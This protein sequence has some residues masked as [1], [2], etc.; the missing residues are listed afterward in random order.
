MVRYTIAG[1]RDGFGSQ[2]HGIMAGIAYCK[3]MNYEYVHTPMSH[4]SHSQN[5]NIKKFNNLIGIPYSQNKT[6]D[7]DI[8]KPNSFT[9]T[10]IGKNPDSYFTNDVIK[11]IRNYYY[12]NSKPDIEEIDIAIHVRRGDVSDKTC[13]EKIKSRY[14]SND[15]YVKI[16][17]FMRKKYPNLKITI[18]S[19]GIIDD[20]KELQDDNISFELNSD[21]I[22][23]FHSFVK[24][25]VFVMAKSSLS[26]CAGILNEN[27]IYYIDWWCRPLNKWNKLS[28]LI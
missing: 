20:F 9:G 11:I 19:E 6:T 26:F 16:I 28:S 18:F 7:I 12:L 13:N 15:Y 27:E 5:K 24:A 4:I 22:Q 10:N 23:S 14:T 17:N 1:K 21:L 25:K 8:I 3:K 2:Y